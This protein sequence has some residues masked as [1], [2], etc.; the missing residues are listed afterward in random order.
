MNLKQQL[1]RAQLELTQ[2][3]EQHQLAVQ[4]AH[5]RGK[6]E[7]L[8]EIEE[9]ED[10]NLSEQSAPDV[11]HMTPLPRMLSDEDVVINSSLRPEAPDYHGREPDS[12]LN[13]ASQQDA[14]LSVIREGQLQQQKML[15]LMN[16]PK[17]EMPKFDGDKLKYWTFIQSFE[18][19]YEHAD[20]KTK[21]LHLLN[22]CEGKARDL[23]N[24]CMAMKPS[25]GYLRARHILN[26][27]YGDEFDVVQ[28]WVKKVTTGNAIKGND[29]KGLQHYADELRQC[30]EILTS[31]SK[32]AEMDNQTNLVKVVERLPYHM[33]CKWRSKVR[34]VKVER[35]RLPNFHDLVCFI[36]IT[37]EEMNDPVFGA[38]VVHVN[39]RSHPGKDNKTG[40]SKQRD[41]YNAETRKESH[42]YKC[43]V[44]H[45]GQH[46]LHKCDK[47][48]AMSVEK[49]NEY[50]RVNR[51]CYN[52]L[53]NGHGFRSDHC[54]YRVKCDINGCGKAHNRLLHR[55]EINSDHQGGNAKTVNHTPGNTA[56]HNQNASNDDQP[57]NAECNSVFGKTDVKTRCIALPIV[58]IKVSTLGGHKS[59]DTYALLDSGSNTTFC[60][61]YLAKKLGIKGKREKVTMNTLT[62]QQCIVEFESVRLKVENI[63]GDSLPV[64]LSQVY[65]KEKMNICEESVAKQVDVNQWSHLH[66]INLPRIEGGKVHMLIGQDNPQLL[67]PQEIRSGAPGSPY[68]IKTSL[69]WMLNGPVTGVDNGISSHFAQISDIT[70]TADQLTKMWE[71]EAPEMAYDT[72]KKGLSVNDRKVVSLWDRSINKV[73]GHYELPIPFVADVPKL[74]DNRATAEKRLN[75]L[76]SRLLRDPELR[77]KYTEEM[78]KLTDQGFAEKVPDDKIERLDG[79]V[80]YLPHFCV[81]TDKKPDKL[82][83]VF[84]GS[85]KQGT[86]KSLNDHIMQGP[87]LTNSLVGVLLRLRMN[88]I[89]IISDIQAMFNQCRV[90]T[91]DRDALRYFWWPSGDLSQP[92]EIYRMRTHMFGGVW[93]P[94]AANY[95]L[96]H[97]AKDDGHKYTPDISDSV[98]KDFYVDDYV[99]SVPDSE[100]GIRVAGDVTKLVAEG[101]FRLTKWVSN[102]RDVLE[103]IPESERAPNQFSVDLC[104]SD[105]ETVLGNKWNIQTDELT[106]DVT[107]REK[108]VTKRGILSN[109]NGVFDPLGLIA[110]FVLLGKQLLQ[111]LTRLKLGWDDPIP[112]SL[113][114]KWESWLASLRD[115]HEMKIPRR[116][117]TLDNIV[118]YELH[119]F[120]DASLQGVAVASY[121]RTTDS[122]GRVDCSLLYASAKLT[123]VRPLTVPRLEL[124]G[125]NLAVKID[126]MLRAELHVELGESTFWCDSA[127]VLSYIANESK[128]F[129]IF[130]ANRVAQIRDRTNP[131]Q[132]RFIPTQLNPADYP[133]RGMYAK[134]LIDCR[135]WIQ[136]PD[137]L[138]ESEDK[139]PS[140]VTVSRPSPDDPELKRNIVTCNATVTSPVSVIWGKVSS[141]FT[142]TKLVAWL[143]KVKRILIQR[144]RARKQG[145]HADTCTD[146]DRTVRSKLTLGDMR[147]AE[148]EILKHVQQ[149]SFNDDIANLNAGKLVSRGSKLRKLDPI[150]HNGLLRVGGRLGNAPFASGFKHPIILPKNHDV[151][152]IIIR[153]AHEQVA[154]MGTEY[155]L[156]ET[157]A[158]FWILNGRKTVRRVI[159]ECMKCK[160]QQSGVG[161]A[162]MADLPAER[163]TPS[164]F[165]FEATGID[166]FGP[167]YIKRGRVMVKR[168]GCLFTCMKSRAVHIEILHSLD[169][170]SFIKALTRFINRRTRPSVIM[171]DNG[172][173]FVGAYRQLKAALKS[174]DQSQI[175]SLCLKHNI[176]WKFSPPTGAHFGGIWESQVKVAKRLL[177]NLMGEQ[178]ISDED[179]ATLACQV[180]QIMNSRPLTRVSDDINDL[181]ALT[182]N[183]LLLLRPDTDLPVGPTVSQDLYCRKRWKQIR[184]LSDKF[185]KRWTREYLTNLQ[186]RSKWQEDYQNFK[187]GDLVLVVDELRS[188]GKWP[189]G[190]VVNCFPSKDGRVRVV[191]VKTANGLFT[192]PIVKLCHLEAD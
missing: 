126:S 101:G 130:V 137:F 63:S 120:S 46:P 53:R 32:V 183:H 75:S 192:R 154:H 59:F 167:Y 149:E 38:S 97:V 103:T 48:K 118:K 123:P 19:L 23:V 67:V 9:E 4:A 110:P 68:A 164:N 180:E 100:T 6:V 161:K 121:L 64:T 107:I 127:I 181:D 136:G 95:I 146:N 10:E 96:Q 41:V 58:A 150:L 52:C 62:S 76:K 132:W 73:D 51:R 79:K 8:Q 84:D 39:E 98:R 117:S 70:G 129:Q 61:G 105:S 35:Q 37:A 33:Q 99:K 162:K 191:Q 57:G 20:N 81:R 2:Q 138:T 106:Y 29:A 122:D 60:S 182:P 157:R 173:N 115:L 148:V 85:C 71:I 175:E 44:C 141:L 160:R 80:Y 125:A 27:R 166:C 5:A 82:R 69:G 87:D 113:S 88:P 116:V 92:P 190:K 128:R 91:N 94:A 168:Y 86:E 165:P 170:D 159:R 66:G 34:K 28:N 189:L 135:T 93:S 112:D 140:R 21:L 108:K 186:K 43:E 13:T 187:I 178:T 83:V 54:R 144:V 179:L 119:H 50:V 56:L 147:D 25:E 14:L 3:N 188:R 15:T 72:E 176:V 1:E 158:K 65:V 55:G 40:K 24:S 31:V 102:C 151:V 17:V 18:N 172:T 16:I 177:S 155:T 171:C 45:Q 49:R 185:W 156:S 42:M 89:V 30:L 142:L 74:P 36:E 109:V 11:P 47:F 78:E 169:T 12:K 174:L 134:D 145:D 184:H 124:I 7:S 111:E 133:S 114:D 153:Q 22:A 77:E 90:T 131:N 152:T 104:A 143:L 163:L 139:W 26:T